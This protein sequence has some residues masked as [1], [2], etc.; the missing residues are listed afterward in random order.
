MSGSALRVVLV[1]QTCLMEGGPGKSFLRQNQIFPGAS[2][3]VDG[4]VLGDSA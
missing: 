3:R 2:D 4:V 1:A